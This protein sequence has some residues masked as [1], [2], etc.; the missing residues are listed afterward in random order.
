MLSI[1][2]TLLHLIILLFIVLKFFRKQK[3]KPYPIV[4][5][6]WLLL[7][8]TTIY[9]VIISNTLKNHNTNILSDVLFTPS[10]LMGMY[11]PLAF[12]IT[13]CISALIGIRK[14]IS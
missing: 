7:I 4:K 3:S 11:L 14:W 6:T 13:I 1:L 12:L 8:I 2:S 10:L 5:T 9:V